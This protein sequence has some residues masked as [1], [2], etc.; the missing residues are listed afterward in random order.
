MMK[1]LFMQWA[2]V[3][4]AE[5]LARNLVDL[6]RRFR[7]AQRL[8]PKKRLQPKERPWLKECLR[9]KKRLWSEERLRL[10]EPPQLTGRP[11]RIDETVPVRHV[12]LWCLCGSMAIGQVSAEDVAWPEHGLNSAETRYSPLQDINRDTV[13]DLGL[14]WSHT[15]GTRRGLEAS[16]IMV[17]RTLYV[18]SAWSQVHAF[19]AVTGE[20]K[21]SYNPEV[22]K[23]WGANACC[24]VVNRGVAVAG[25]SVLV[26]TLDGYLVSL[27]RQDGTVNWRVLTIDPNRPYT[28]TGAPRVIGDLVVIGNGGAEYGVRGYV[29]AYDI[30][31][32][33]EAWRFYTVPGDP[34]QP[35]EHEALAIAQPTWMGREYLV[36]GGGGTVWDSMAYD[37]DLGLLYIGVG[38]GAPWNREV[39]S[40]GGGDNL[41][42]SSIVALEAETG[43]YRWHYQT[44]PGDTWDYTATQHMILAELEIDGVERPVIMQAP[45][46]GFFYVLD[47]TDG[48]LLSAEPYVAINWATHVDPETGR[49]VETPDARYTEQLELIRPAPFGGHNWHPMAYHPEDGLVYIPAM[50]NLS[51]YASGADNFNYLPGPHWN[52]GQNDAAAA[53]S[54]LGSM[55][56]IAL[57]PLVDEL[58]QGVLVAWDPV[59]Q[60]PRWSQPLPTMWN[61]GV[62]ATSGG[63]VFQGNGSGALV[64][65][66][67]DT[68]DSLWSFQAP[69]GIVAPPVTYKIDGQQYVAV[70]AG[71]GGAVGLV[72]AQQQAKFGQQGTLMVFKLGG[73]AE[74]APV[75]IPR[76]KTFALQP[77]IANESEEA[78]GAALYNQHCMRCHGIGA[79]SQ[80]LVPDLRYMSQATH[81]IFGAIVYDGVLEGAGMIG[82]SDVMSEDEVSAVHA[83]LIKTAID[84][85]DG[86][87]DEPA[88]PTGIRATLLSWL[89]QLLDRVL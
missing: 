58:M 4:L 79:V 3:R 75:A 2:L 48:T 27:R 36:S 13:A 6:A 43:E 84:A 77:R 88:P 50:R 41:F 1:R 76:A 44:T 19:D 62:L 8:Q 86:S 47:R 5:R 14:A 66:A 55:D 26:G 21:W 89:G 12:V 56:P 80:G 7:S 60:Q 87:R 37:A 73:D 70:L 10:E 61:G 53:D 59:E 39:R 33:E 74:L 18:S 42:L 24:D 63:L 45:K 34:D 29:T 22:P 67:S 15:M 82:F 17:D 31:T 38:N 49:P 30:E 16:P 20:L 64:A 72:L 25:D 9:P 11:W 69:T 46:N 35:V 65:Y 28:I 85:A 40:P 57:A 51:A 78:L 81:D 54:P 71:W 23:A 68:G 32:G 52:T 83:Y